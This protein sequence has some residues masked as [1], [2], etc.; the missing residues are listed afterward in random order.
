MTQSDGLLTTEERAA[1]ETMATASDLN[2]R[3]AAALLAVDAGQTQA[4]AAA[5]AGLTEGQLRYFL[6]KFH[7]QRLDAFSATSEETDSPA[8]STTESAAETEELR[9]RVDELNAL[10]AEL[11]AKVAASGSPAGEG[12]YTPTRLLGTVRDSLHKL[13]PDAQMGILQSFEGM[14]AEDLLDLDTWKGLAY[15]MT[16]SARFQ[17]EQIRDRVS[18]TINQVVPEPI[19]PGRLWQMGRKGLDKITPDFARQILSTFEGASRE[20]LLDPDTWKGV[21]YMISYSLQFQAE[22]WKQKLLESEQAN[23]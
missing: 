12:N 6:R 17:A 20:D 4:A 18:G 15:M 10:V 5:A 11:Q 21:W 22:Q 9:R 19:Q 7:E 2:G 23:S 16:Y 3:R 14:T 13:A 8:V 1:C